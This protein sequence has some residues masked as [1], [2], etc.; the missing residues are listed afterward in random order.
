MGVK[1]VVSTKAQEGSV[2]A[3]TNKVN[4]EAIGLTRA[5]EVYEPEAQ[6]KQQGKPY[7]RTNLP[8]PMKSSD[9]SR[10]APTSIALAGEVVACG[11]VW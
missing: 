7:A 11:R 4:N 10:L 5:R 1:S 3:L 9:F 6:N 2:K 8:R